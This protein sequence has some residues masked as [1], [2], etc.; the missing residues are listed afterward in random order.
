M[1]KSAPM[2]NHTIEIKPRRR[3]GTAFALLLTMLL[4]AATLLAGVGFF[5]PARLALPQEHMLGLIHGGIAGRV[6]HTFVD[7]C[8]QV[9]G[10]DG[11]QAITRTVRTI[12]FRDGTSLSVIFSARP[13]PM[14]AGC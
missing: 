12:T 10:A 13:T 14:S 7:T 3:A 8:M 2:R 9:P 4:L 11:P 1:V 6:E 5:S